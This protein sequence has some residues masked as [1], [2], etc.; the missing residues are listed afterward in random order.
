MFD[1]LTPDD[2]RALRQLGVGRRHQRGTYLMLEGDRSDHAL[3]ICTGRVKIVR[4]SEEGRE[5]VVA[6]RGA[7]EVVGELT[8]LAGA[9]RN[10]SIVALCDVTVR[11]IPANELLAFVSSRPAVSRAMIRQLAMRLHE[12]TSRQA[13]AAGYDSLRRVARV[14]LEQ[15]EHYGEQVIGGVKAGP[16][17]TQ[18]ELAGLVSASPTSVARALARLRSQGLVTTARRSVVILDLEGMRRF[19]S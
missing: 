10:A 5:S 7:G 19:V 1:E 4:T 3:L 8:A 15:A 9:A 17:L 12:A 2:A 18:Q 14:L 16:G 6:V 11:A 13:D